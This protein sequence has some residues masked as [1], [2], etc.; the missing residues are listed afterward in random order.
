VLR[1]RPLTESAQSA[2]G[3]YGRDADTT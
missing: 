1:M 3:A 2:T